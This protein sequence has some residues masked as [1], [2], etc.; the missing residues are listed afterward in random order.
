MDDALAAARANHVQEVRN[1][2]RKGPTG[3][4]LQRSPLVTWAKV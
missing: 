3:A 4:R 1:D 2:E